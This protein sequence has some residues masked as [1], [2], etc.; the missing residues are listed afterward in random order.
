MR[1]YCGMDFVGS[2][3]AQLAGRQ[4]VVGVE[5]CYLPL[6]GE[7]P[8]ASLESLEDIRG[9]GAGGCKR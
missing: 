6:E 2:Q 1:Q 7:E 5:V 9:N 4:V 8:L 3:S